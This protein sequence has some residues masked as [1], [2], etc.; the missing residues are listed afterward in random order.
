MILHEYNKRCEPTL[1]KITGIQARLTMKSNATPVFLKARPVPFKLIPLLEK[2]LDE[3]VQA[4]ILT[5]V[6][7]SEWATHCSSTKS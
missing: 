7:N 3:L 6:E 5:K 1:A 4:G 2:E